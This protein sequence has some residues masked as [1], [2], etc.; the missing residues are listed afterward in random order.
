MRFTLHPGAERDIAEAVAFYR[1]TAGIDVAQRLLDEIFRVISLLAE[2]PALG[3]PTTAGK[4]RFPLHGFPYSVTVRD[5]STHVRVLVVA[6]QH[7]RPK[8]G[9]HR[10]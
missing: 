9:S 1:G 3:A 8:F 10:K 4:R 5:L 7:R 2:N 6:H